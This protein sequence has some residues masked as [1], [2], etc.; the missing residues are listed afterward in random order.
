[1]SISC[2]YDLFKYPF[3]LKDT[4]SQIMVGGQLKLAEDAPKID[5]VIGGD[6]LVE[7]P[8]YEVNDGSVFISGRLQPH[9]LY[10]AREEERIKQSSHRDAE[11]QT[12]EEQDIYQPREYG[13]SWTGEAG[14]TYEERIEIP[15]LSP[16]MMVEVE[17]VPS[18]LTF[19]KDAP[20]RVAFNGKLELIIHT[21]YYQTAQ[22][23]SDLTALAQEKININKELLA[24]EEI[25]SAKTVAFTM[26]PIVALPRIKPGAC[27]ILDH[28]VKPVGLY[29]EESRGKIMVK[30][31]LDLD[32][33]YVGCDDEGQ[34]TEIF[35]NNWNQA[36]GTAIP[37]ET[38]L[39]VE[40]HGE[41]LFVIP[42]IAIRNITF[43]LISSHEMHCQIDLDCYARI[44]RIAQKEI[45]VDVDSGAGEIIDSQKYMLNVEEF[46]GEISGEINLDQEPELP[47]NFEVPERILSCR[48]TL[49]DFRVESLDGKALVEGSLEL[50]LLY[51]ADGINR[52]KLVLAKWNANNNNALAVTGM[53]D[54]TGLQPGA[55]VR[56]YVTLDS[57]QVELTGEK[58]LRLTATMKTRI[59]ARTPRA[60]LVLKDC[61]SVV[62]VDPGLRP[63]ML[64]YLV[65]PGD[66][67]WKIARLYQ[68]TVE[69]LARTN[70][71]TN[72]D[73]LETGQ[74]L[75][76]PK[77][78]VNA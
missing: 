65:Q 75:L 2:K 54:F 9:L 6:V 56:T 17:V 16:E 68:T 47:A 22:V 34:P 42:R 76:I 49:K 15:G 18:D 3:F 62:P 29:C 77:Q 72:T 51:M 57:L 33:I 73:R 30:G 31:Y 11:E 12:D 10:L 14:L 40:P 13:Y 74:K 26:R 20:D 37:F 78:I 4:G 23:I 44:S 32:L 46:A 39:D 1:M 61:A 71:I 28:V 8:H 7:A 21:A 52:S 36:N 41:N 35:V 50:N 70:R 67:L 69:S 60:I 63:S 38:Y 45:A 48:G 24:V 58:G 25:L 66:T 64:F 59:F 5:L 19:S 43:D 53:I 55:I 27:R